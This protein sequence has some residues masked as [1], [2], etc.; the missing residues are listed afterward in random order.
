[1]SIE[2]RREAT[3]AASPNETP[4]RRIAFER[5]RERTDELELIISGLTVFALFALPDAML[6]AWFRMQVHVEGDL[7]DIL[8][9][10]FLFA[11]GLSYALGL[12]FVAHLV[13]RAY[14]VGLIGL[15]SVFPSGIRWDRTHTMGPI[16][17]D[18]FKRWLP[19]IDT[20]IDRADRVASIIFAL[21]SLV[22]ILVVWVAV[23]IAILTGLA[24][25]VKLAIGLSDRSTGWILAGAAMSMV[26]LSLVN[27]MLDVWYAAKR[28]AL[29]ANPRFRAGLETSI[30]VANAI[31]PQRLILPVQLTLQSNLPARRFLAGFMIAVLLIP[32]AGAA[33]A[34][35]RIK[36]APVNS[37]AF[38]TDDMA[39]TALRSAYYETLRSADDEALWLPMIQSD[40]IAESHLRVFL[41]HLPGR[42]NAVLAAV[43]PPPAGETRD[44]SA[45]AH[46]LGSVWR[47]RLDGQDQPMTDFVPAERRDLGLRGLQGYLPLAGMMPGRHELEVIWNDSGPDEGSD[48]RRTYA[49]PFWFAPGY[50]L[51]VE[52][53]PS[54]GAPPSIQ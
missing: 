4:E 2:D 45:V 27:W 22:G 28:P 53:V 12:T 50:E 1:M 8:R 51:S 30:R 29:Q 38:F 26:A 44:R 20:A 32:L 46:C 11:S 18:Y 10:V 54:V 31:S 7:V 36:F 43:C 21:A 47:V 52:A 41:P 6:S 39:E 42:D 37:Y 5:L 48:R 17:R 25:L 40:R 15:K 14:W 34:L 35:A 13:V 33:T 9:T 16:G 23:L 3:S 24:A 19:D 49:I